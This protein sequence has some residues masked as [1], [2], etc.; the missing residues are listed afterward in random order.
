MK[1]WLISPA[2]HLGVL[3]FILS[4]SSSPVLGEQTASAPAHHGMAIASKLCQACHEFKGADQAGTVGPPF[5]SMTAR[6]P[7]R[8]RLRDIIFDAHQHLGPDTMM[9]P[10]GRHGLIN[11]QETE[12]L[13]DFLYTL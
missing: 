11:E 7:E 12:T 3:A 2:N 5:A 9:P 1:A 10:F 6:F 13:I 8:K 4:L